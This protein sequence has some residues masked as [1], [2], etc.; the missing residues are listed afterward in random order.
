MWENTTPS[1][2]LPRVFCAGIGPLHLGVVLV[3]YKSKA[4]GLEITPFED[5]NLEIAS[6]SGGRPLDPLDMLSFEIQRLK[7]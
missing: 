5:L 6:A 4:E 7:G 3:F 2:E 1:P